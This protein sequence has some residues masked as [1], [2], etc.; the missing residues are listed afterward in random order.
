MF[1]SKFTELGEKYSSV[2]SVEVETAV[3]FAA[4]YEG[5]VLKTVD[6]ELKREFFK[7]TTRED[8]DSVFN[9]NGRITREGLRAISDNP[10]A[11]VSATGRNG[12]C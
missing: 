11:C 8:Y 12:I 5:A 9:F 6:T 4:I 1:D 2:N 3:N 7:A 10:L